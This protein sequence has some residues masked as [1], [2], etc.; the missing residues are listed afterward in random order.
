MLNKFGHHELNTSPDDN[1]STCLR[2]LLRS[3]RE[4]EKFKIGPYRTIEDNIPSANSRYYTCYRLPG[5][6]KQLTVR[7]PKSLDMY[8]LS[9]HNYKSTLKYVYTSHYERCF[10]LHW[11]MD[12]RQINVLS[13][14]GKYDEQRVADIHTQGSTLNLLIVQTRSWIKW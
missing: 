2:L 5:L 3:F 1:C 8:I 12:K 4:R 11:S 7:T 9:H 14:C 10:S 13:N 6:R